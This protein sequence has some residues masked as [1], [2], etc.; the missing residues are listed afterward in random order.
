[1]VVRLQSV[2][3]AGMEHD[4]TLSTSPASDSELSATTADCGQPLTATSQGLQATNID[5][6]SESGLEVGDQPSVK[7]ER[8]EV[9]SIDSIEEGTG[10]VSE[11][12]RELETSCGDTDDSECVKKPRLESDD[13]E[14]GRHSAKTDTD[15]TVERH[16]RRHN[17]STSA[18]VL[19]GIVKSRVRKIAAERQHDAAAK[20][21]NSAASSS[22]RTA[23]TAASLLSTA[24]SPKMNAAAS[25]CLMSIGAV[26]L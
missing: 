7:K 14:D 19:L 21:S 8:L 1:M 24:S 25:E 5:T 22:S 6:G 13:N 17:K 16:D 3:D 26:F 11:A 2:T 20:T 4:A 18:A 9:K 23:L 12:G 10:S 15:D